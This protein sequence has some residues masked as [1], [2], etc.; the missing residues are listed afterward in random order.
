M[1]IKEHI[2]AGHYEHD[3]K[4]RALVPIASGGTAVI[5][6]TDHPTTW[7]ITGREQNVGILGHTW[8]EDGS[9]EGE[10]DCPSTLDLLP[11]PPR[12]VKITA[13]CV[14]NWRVGV[15]P[16]HGI[17]WS[18]EHALEGCNGLPVIELTGEYE[19]PWS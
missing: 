14:P 18:R 17:W 15:H 11:P 3:D 5:Y 10:A 12:K 7:C 19:E 13:Y 2:E 8:N 9:H 6:A 16:M 1:N 4:G